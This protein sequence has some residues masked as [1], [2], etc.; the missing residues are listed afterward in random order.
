[1]SIKQGKAILRAA[2]DEDLIMQL[3]IAALKTLV[4]PNMI[5]DA[6]LRFYLS[7]AC[8]LES[9]KKLKTGAKDD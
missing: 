5:V 2:L 4:N 9:L 1:M 7:D 3:K 6:A 8:H